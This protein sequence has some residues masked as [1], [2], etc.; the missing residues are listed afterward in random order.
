MA[1]ALSA[2][3]ERLRQTQQQATAAALPTNK[4]DV[5]RPVSLLLTPVQAAE[6]DAASLLEEGRVALLEL[7]ELD[8]SLSAFEDSLFNQKS[9]T[10]ERELQT[11]EVRV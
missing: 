1:S 7:A 6:V 9:L 5:P 8:P 10:I 2:Q 4:R 3:I 11:P